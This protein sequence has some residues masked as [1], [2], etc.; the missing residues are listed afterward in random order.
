SPTGFKMQALTGQTAS[1]DWVPLPAG[2]TV[3]Y[4]SSVQVRHPDWLGS[5]RFTSD[6]GARTMLSDTA[7]APFGEPYAQAGTT[8][9]SFTGMDQ[10]TSGSLYDFPA[11]KYGIQGRWPSP[12]PAGLAAANPPTPSP[13]TATPTSKIIP[14]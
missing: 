11:R 9:L 7:Y 5:S 10:D 8:D 2:A 1:K 14:S 12:D 6:L 4:S 13:G 3:L